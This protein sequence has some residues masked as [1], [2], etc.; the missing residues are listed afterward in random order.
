MW[1]H[2][3]LDNTVW[4]GNGTNQQTVHSFQLFWRQ[5]GDDV[6][7]PLVHVNASADAWR[8]RAASATLQASHSLILTLRVYVGQKRQLSRKEHLL[9]L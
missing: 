9:L 3:V 4:N 7:H 8:H 2:L 5:R 6:V 1:A